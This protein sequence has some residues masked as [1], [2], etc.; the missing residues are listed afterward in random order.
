[1]SKY[2]KG[3][4]SDSYKCRVQHYICPVIQT[5]LQSTQ[6]CTSGRNRI[7]CHLI[8]NTDRMKQNM[9]RK[10]YTFSQFAFGISHLVPQTTST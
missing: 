4:D 2:L 9:G 3:Y 5:Y 7:F 1:M 10:K 8:Q 6:K